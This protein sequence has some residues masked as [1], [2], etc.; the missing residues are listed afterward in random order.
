M[1]ENL[2]KAQRLN[3]LI[4]IP[5]FIIFVVGLIASAFIR[6]DDKLFESI[7]IGYFGLLI[8]IFSSIGFYYGVGVGI[9]KR[10]FGRISMNQA[11]DIIKSMLN[12]PSDPK[13]FIIY[14]GLVNKIMAFLSF[15][16][17]SMMIIYAFRR[18]G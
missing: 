5:A 10:S 11:S 18:L 7:V 17:G 9:K 12:D 2:Q 15:L 13:K 3:V 1:K 6:M 4:A 8:M 16:I 14:T